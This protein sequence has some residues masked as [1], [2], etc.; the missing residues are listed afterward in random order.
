GALSNQS[1]RVSVRWFWLASE[2]P[3]HRLAIDWQETDG[4]AVSA[5]S[6]F[7]YGTRIIREL[8]PYELGGT[9][10]LKFAPG[11]VQCRLEIPAAWSG[12]NRPEPSV[13][14]WGDS[15]AARASC[16]RV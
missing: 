12:D 2:T 14:P 11:G 5:P 16:S 4:P 1:G 6:A 13:Q 3:H 8:L 15:R 7:G 10:D 9:V